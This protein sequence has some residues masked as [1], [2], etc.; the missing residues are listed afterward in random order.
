MSIP[1]E[2]YYAS[3]PL[4]FEW[5][6][7]FLKNNNKN[8]QASDIQLVIDRS[9]HDKE[10][11]NNSENVIKIIILK[12]GDVYTSSNGRIISDGIQLRQKHIDTIVNCNYD[13]SSINPGSGKEPNIIIEMKKYAIKEDILKRKIKKIKHKTKEKMKNKIYNKM[14]ELKEKIE[15]LKSNINVMKNYN[16]IPNNKTSEVEKIVVDSIDLSQSSDEDDFMNDNISEINND[17]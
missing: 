10:V 1:I 6:K 9:W 17:D 8:I 5:V 3:N 15:Q 12:N 13:M 2:N 14:K 11:Q 4:T 16:I 7:K